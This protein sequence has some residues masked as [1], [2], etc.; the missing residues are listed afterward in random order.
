MNSDMEGRMQDQI[1]GAQVAHAEA[2]KEGYIQGLKDAVGICRRI[3]DQSERFMEQDI[4]NIGTNY[5]EAKRNGATHCQR[6]I[7]ALLAKT[8]PTA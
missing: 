5:Y 1:E 4:A 7:R 8:D 3:A 2:M 6:D